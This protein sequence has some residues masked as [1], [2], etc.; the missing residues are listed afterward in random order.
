MFKNQRSLANLSH[1]E[2]AFTLS[3]HHDAIKSQGRRTDLVREI[4][5]M[6]QDETISAGQGTSG[7]VVL[8][9]QSRDKAGF[10]QGLSGRNV[11]RYLRV[12]QLIGREVVIR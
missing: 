7:P 5:E 4:E 8:K 3:I 1:S 10:E 9:S 6:L 12:N 2:R 11:S